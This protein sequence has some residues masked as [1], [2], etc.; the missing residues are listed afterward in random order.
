MATPTPTLRLSSL[1]SGIDTQRDIAIY[2]SIHY[3]TAAANR[4]EAL[5]ILKDDSTLKMTIWQDTNDTPPTFAFFYRESKNKPICGPI[6]IVPSQNITSL[7]A[8][9]E[10]IS[11]HY[12][13]ESNTLDHE[14]FE[15][16]F[17]PNATISFQLSSTL[18]EYLTQ[19]NGILALTIKEAEER[20]KK[21]PGNVYVICPQTDEKFSLIAKNNNGLRINEMVFPQVQLSDKISNLSEYFFS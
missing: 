3:A 14:H 16:Y 21:I 4:N 12:D 8:A 18:S 19:T 9:C 1:Y 20:L 2:L 7:D 6:K 11:L 13:P 15:E 17:L 10:E 5:T